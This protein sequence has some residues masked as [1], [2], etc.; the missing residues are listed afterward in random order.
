MET[1]DI[2]KETI[3]YGSVAGAM[4]AYKIGKMSEIIGI[5]KPMLYV[6]LMQDENDKTNDGPI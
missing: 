5:S 4:G 1:M 6:G 3:I 2:V